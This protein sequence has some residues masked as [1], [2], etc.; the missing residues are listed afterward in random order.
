MAAL[1][2][3][4]FAFPLPKTVLRT[5]LCPSKNGN[6]ELTPNVTIFGDYSFKKV[7]KA[8]RGHKGGILIYMTGALKEEKKTFKMCR[9][10]V[11]AR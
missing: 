10:R 9:H 11:K 5:E 7:N 8:K 3:F 6:V 4:S 2:H 1:F